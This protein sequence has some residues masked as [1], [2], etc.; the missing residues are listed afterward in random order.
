MRDDSL[1]DLRIGALKLLN[2]L[3]LDRFEEDLAVSRINLRP[4][5]KKSKLTGALPTASPPKLRDA[6]NQ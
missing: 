6:G 1:G 3:A 2:L 4:A 5:Q